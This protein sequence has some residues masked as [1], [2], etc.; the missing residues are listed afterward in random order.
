MDLFEK[1]ARRKFRFPSSVGLLGVEDVYALPLTDRR[2]V[3]LDTV[4]RAINSELKGKEEE[5]FVPSSSGVD[6]RT[7]DLR[8]MLEIVKRVISVKV[9]ERDKAAMAADKREK[10]QRI[11][12]ALAKKRDEKI[13]QASE[14]DLLKELEAIDAED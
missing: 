13:D 7:R 9:A 8:D 11:L 14:E 3:N 12:E 10:K 6:A 4:A 5:S 2:G 1:A